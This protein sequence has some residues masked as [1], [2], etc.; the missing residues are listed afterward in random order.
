VQ[1]CEACGADFPSV[2]VVN[3]DSLDLRGRKHCLACRPHRPLRGPRKPVHRDPKP[4]VCEQCGK[5]FPAKQLID[6]VM[7]SLYRRRFCLDCSPFGLHNT[8]RD[9]VRG[10]DA[11]ARKAAKRERRLQS[12]LRS[13]NKRRRRR[14]RELVEAR[15]GQ[16][17][18]CGYSASVEALQFH[19]RDPSTKD[20]RLGDFSGSLERF[21]AEAAKC[22]LVCANCHRLRHL[23]QGAAGSAAV[24]KAR[25]EM[26]R[27]A[28]SLFG[29]A[30]HE[31]RG[32]F[33]P[34]VFDFHHRDPAGKDF[35][36]SDKG[37]YRSW[38]RTVAELEKCVMVCAN[39]HA[40]IHA[41]LRELAPGLAA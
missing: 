14:K 6:G 26:K 20:F 35:G 28:V 41:G 40:E 7:R 11:E 8:S 15:G 16:C 3:G 33:P 13:L 37:I 18:D 2:L 17:M 19:H 24:V 4:L 1:T 9:P 23:A 30:C 36:L 34:G 38:E 10:P 32:V 27:R 21:L 22:D 25:R 12:Y 5:V 29:G 39:C 31:C